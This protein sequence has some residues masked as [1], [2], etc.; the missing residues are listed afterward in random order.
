[1]VFC[2]VHNRKHKGQAAK[3][4]CLV[5]QRID[6]PWEEALGRIKEMENRSPDKNQHVR[7][8]W[9]ISPKAVDNEF[10]MANEFKKF[11]N[12]NKLLGASQ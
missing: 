10:W 6:I 3:M 1:M 7:D 2:T 8:V 9:A 11:A 12:K 5:S 4:A